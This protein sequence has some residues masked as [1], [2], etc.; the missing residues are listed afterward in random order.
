VIDRGAVVVDL[1]YHPWETPWLTTLRSRGVE[2][3]NGAGMLVGQAALAF[4]R[5]TG[6]DAPYEAMLGA[7]SLDLQGRRLRA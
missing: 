1:V 2:C 4:E 3:R 5:W 6:V 7:A